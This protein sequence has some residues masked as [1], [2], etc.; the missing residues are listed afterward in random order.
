LHEL[1]DILIAEQV[2]FA[3]NLD[4]GGSSVLTEEKGR[5][6]SHPTCLDIP[7][8]CERAVSTVLCIPCAQGNVSDADD[9]DNTWFSKNGRIPE[10]HRFLEGL[11]KS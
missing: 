3:I 7:F 10:A 8:R 9:D 5:I 6:I 1:A 2:T 4:G 11:R